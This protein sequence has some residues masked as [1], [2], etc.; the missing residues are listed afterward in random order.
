MQRL[1]SLL[2][3]W[4]ALAGQF[5]TA[6]SPGKPNNLVNILKTTEF[7]TSKCGFHGRNYI[8]KLK[9]KIMENSKSSLNFIFSGTFFLYHI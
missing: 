7:Y 9:I 8:I 3:H 2:L 4:Q 1:N 5:L 6:E